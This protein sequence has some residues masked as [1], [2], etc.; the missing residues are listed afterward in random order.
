MTAHATRE[1]RQTALWAWGRPARRG[2][3]WVQPCLR[4]RRL[5]W[6]AL[7]LAGPGLLRTLGQP[8]ALSKAA[9]RQTG[10]PRCQVEIP[11]TWNRA[12]HTPFRKSL[13]WPRRCGW[14]VPV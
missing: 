6:A 12:D 10:R 3:F 5:R 7:V 9:Y 14:P 4:E 13:G 1:S 11:Q 2:L 8:P